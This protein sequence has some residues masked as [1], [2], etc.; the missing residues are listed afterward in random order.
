M[1]AM[2]LLETSAPAGTPADAS[3]C[4]V[5]RLL[6][7]AAELEAQRAQQGQHDSRAVLLD[8]AERLPQHSMGPAEHERYWDVDG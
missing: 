3:R 8:L 2:T 1:L 4:H 5:N 6:R 7:A